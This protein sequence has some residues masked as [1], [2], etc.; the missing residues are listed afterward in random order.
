MNKIYFYRGLP[1]SGKTTAAHAQVAASKTPIIRVNKDDLRL[2]L[3]HGAWTRGNE[4]IVLEVRDRLIITALQAKQNVIVDD[5]NFAPKHL[6]RINEIAAQ[7]KATVEVID[8][9]TPVNVCI[10][11]DSKRLNPVGRNVI[12]KMWRDYIK[13]TIQPPPYNPVLSDAVI[14]DLDG[15][16]SLLNGRNPYDA[17]TCADDK[18]NGPVAFALNQHFNHEQVVLLV[19][20]REDKY[21]PQTEQFLTKHRVRFHKLWMRSSGDNRADTIVKREIYDNHIANKYNVVTVYDDRPC[22]VRMWREMGLFCFDV[23][24]GVEF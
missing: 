7:Y 17:S 6:Q 13:P 9:N 10:E 4:N 2:M 14:C 11:R 15:T 16:L 5:T 12:L 8:V 1:G 20:G 18:L 22:M 23:G 24:D 3:H 19:S 21:F